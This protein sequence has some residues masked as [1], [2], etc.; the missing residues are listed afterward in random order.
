MKITVQQKKKVA[1]KIDW[2]T[3]PSGT[4]VE[5]DNGKQA[6]VYQEYTTTMKPALLLLGAGVYWEQAKGY[7]DRTVTKIIGTIT[8]I[9]VEEN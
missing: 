8:E 1:K 6:I 5:F 7:L 3:L 2:K 9:I 4:V